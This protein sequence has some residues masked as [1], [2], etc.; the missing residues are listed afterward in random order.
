MLVKDYQ[1]AFRSQSCYGTEQTVLRAIPFDVI[2]SVPTEGNLQSHC[3]AVIFLVCLVIFSTLRKNR[4][5]ILGRSVLHVKE[6]YDT[7]KY[8]SKTSALISRKVMAVLGFATQNSSEYC[9]TSLIYCIILLP[10]PFQLLWLQFSLNQLGNLWE[11]W[12]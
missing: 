11:S 12:W 10:D 2:S 8:K 4:D 6:T 9:H 3:S 5:L 1:M 7:C